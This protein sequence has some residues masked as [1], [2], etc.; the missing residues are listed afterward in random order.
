MIL[1]WA[2]KR[3]VIWYQK[4]PR[5]G[6]FLF[7]RYPPSQIKWAC[8]KLWRRPHGVKGIAARRETAGPWSYLHTLCQSRITLIVENARRE[9]AEG[10]LSAVTADARRFSSLIRSAPKPAI[11]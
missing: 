7:L 2:G 1:I 3:V 9:F 11:W 5:W 10:P 6:L 4:A 8:R